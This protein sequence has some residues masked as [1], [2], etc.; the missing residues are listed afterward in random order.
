MGCTRWAAHACQRGEARR[1]RRAG[2]VGEARVDRRTRGV[3]RATLRAWRAGDLSTHAGPYG[4]LLYMIYIYIAQCSSV[5]D[6]I[7]L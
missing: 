4:T 5:Y 1:W 6:I 7:D 2:C 3:R